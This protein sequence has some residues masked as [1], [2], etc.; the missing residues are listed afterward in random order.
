MIHTTKTAKLVNS[1]VLSIK[2]P[3]DLIEYILT[4]RF[5]SIMEVSYLHSPNITLKEK[6][7]C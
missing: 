2:D 3:E 5:I 6:K 4:L 7:C 1:L